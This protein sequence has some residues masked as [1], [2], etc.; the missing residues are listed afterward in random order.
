MW[1][2]KFGRKTP[3]TSGNPAL[4]HCSR[5]APQPGHA[6][7]WWNWWFQLAGFLHRRRHRSFIC[8]TSDESSAW[9]FPLVKYAETCVRSC[10]PDIC[11]DNCQYCTT[12]EMLLKN[13][14]SYAF[15]ERQSYNVMRRSFQSSRYNQSTISFHST[16]CNGDWGKTRICDAYTP[17]YVLSVDE[18][19]TCS[20]SK[21]CDE[22]VYGEE[23]HISGL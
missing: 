11:L 10:A 2:N 19:F 8:V 4:N 21:L 6:N 16:V 18:K 3:L 5:R 9:L 1:W 12:E 17:F 20:L 14:D 22:E 13:E 23:Y 7:A 15:V